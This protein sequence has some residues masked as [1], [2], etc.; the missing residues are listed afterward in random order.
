MDRNS[1]DNILKKRIVHWIY[2]H[3]AMF[4]VDCKGKTDEDFFRTLG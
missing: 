1:E 2:E 3:A 4:D